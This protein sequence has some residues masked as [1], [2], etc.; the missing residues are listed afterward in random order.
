MTPDQGQFRAACREIVE[1]YMRPGDKPDEETR[2]IQRGPTVRRL[3]LED[4]TSAAMR[5]ALQTGLALDAFRVLAEEGI[6]VVNDLQN[7]LTDYREGEPDLKKQWNFWRHETNPLHL[8]KSQKQPYMYRSSIEQAAS[9]YLR[10]PYRAE[11]L[12]RTLVDVLVA[13][14]LYAFGEMMF[15]KYPIG[16]RWLPAQSPIQ[17]KHIL[18]RYFGSQVGNAVFFLA[19]A[20]IAG[21]AFNGFLANVLVFIF[22]ALLVLSTVLLPFTW[23]HQAK[24]RS[25]VW[26]CLH[27]MLETYS[28]LSSD[29][30]ISTRRLREIAVKAADVGVGW[31]GPLFAILDDNIA[32]SGRL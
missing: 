5:H 15:T 28:E 4:V 6:F 7:A 27:G 8:I 21:D 26:K 29:G 20:W 23:R 12:E 24:A 1:N 13:L 3:L 11:R 14:E 32:R 30:V 17:E 10:L 19:G 25:T 2:T 22:F 18:R 16:L 31:P 9:A